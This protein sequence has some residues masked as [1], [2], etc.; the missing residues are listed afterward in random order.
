M[1]N[2]VLTFM[3]AMQNKKKDNLRPVVS[4]PGFSQ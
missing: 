2:L 3:S 4:E 1:S